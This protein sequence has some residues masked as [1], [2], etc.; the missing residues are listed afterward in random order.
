M[1]ASISFLCAGVLF[2]QKFAVEWI[3]WFVLVLAVLAN[4]S[5]FAFWGMIF[6]MRYEAKFPILNIFPLLLR[7]PSLYKVSDKEKGRIITNT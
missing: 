4:V 2:Q 1:I 6:I 3:T 5:F 7:Y